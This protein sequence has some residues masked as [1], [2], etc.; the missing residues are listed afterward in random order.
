MNFDTKTAINLAIGVVGLVGLG[1]TAY[2]IYNK[3]EK[4][5]EVALAEEKEAVTTRYADAVVEG[6][7]AE[8]F[9]DHIRIV[10]ADVNHKL[11][12]KYKDYPIAKDIILS[13][14]DDQC[15]ATIEGFK[16]CA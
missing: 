7:S 14:N 13:H 6:V 8:N 1:F 3:E 11:E 4:T 9:E 5:P 12:K 15:F 16:K 10:W 2:K